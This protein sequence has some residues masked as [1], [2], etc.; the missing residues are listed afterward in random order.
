MSRHGLMDEDACDPWGYIRWRGA[1]K[2]AIRGKNGQAFLKEMLR[3]I[4]ALPE[5][6]LSAGLFE[7]HGPPVQGE[8]QV[9]ALGAVAIS[10]G[11]D[12]SEL[13]PE[14]PDSIGY[15]FQI[16]AALAKEIVWENDEF[17][18]SDRARYERMRRWII[19]NMKDFR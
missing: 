9:C 3:A 18:G 11:L 2:S 8:G 17:N 4:D 1:V 13:D 12:V 10:R 16:S 7:L 19:G 6:R 5:P 15:F 14:D